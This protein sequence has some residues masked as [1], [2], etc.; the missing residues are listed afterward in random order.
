ML[1]QTTTVISEHTEQASFGLLLGL[2]R[3]LVLS[4]LVSQH[5]TVRMN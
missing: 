3:P 4:V 5:L 2:I 1:L